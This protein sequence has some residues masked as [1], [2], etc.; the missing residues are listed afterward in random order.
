[1]FGSATFSYLAVHSPID[2]NFPWSLGYIRKLAF[3]SP[4]GNSRFLCAVNVRRPGISNLQRHCPLM[5]PIHTLVEWS[6]GDS[7][8]VPR[9]INVRP[10]KD[11]NNG[12]ERA[13]TGTTRPH[14]H[15]LFS[16]RILNI[17]IHFTKWKRDLFVRIGTK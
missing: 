14:N 1:M 10:G 16:Y 13:T 11:S 17:L 8:H 4:W 2:I 7:F 9:E 3:G 5:V 6:L 12:V 15:F